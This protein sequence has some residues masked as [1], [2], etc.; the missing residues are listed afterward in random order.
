MTAIFCNVC[1]VEVENYFRSPGFE[2]RC[3]NCKRLFQMFGPG[4]IYM[5]VEE[6]E[7]KEDKAA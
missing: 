6:P 2:Y 1:K 7:K 4:L 5:E 3:P